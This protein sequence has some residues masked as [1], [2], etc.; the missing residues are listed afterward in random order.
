M[1]EVRY[2]PKLPLKFILLWI[3]NLAILLAITF[4][5]GF[6]NVL[7]KFNIKNLTYLY[8]F[9]GA[10]MAGLEQAL[11]DRIKENLFPED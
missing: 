1:S 10:V 4:A 9:I 8:L 7:L 5:T 6:H 3:V 2:V 11:L